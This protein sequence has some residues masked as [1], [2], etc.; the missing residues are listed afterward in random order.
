MS[1]PW[2]QKT[3][4]LRF[5]LMPTILIQANSPNKEGLLDMDFI[6]PL[7]RVIW[8][9]MTDM[10]SFPD[11]NDMFMIELLHLTTVLIHHFP[12][13]IEDVKKDIISCAWHYIT[14]EDAVV[15]QMAYLLAVHFFEAFDTPQKFILQA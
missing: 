15:K 12:E 14:S 2:A 4:S 3:F 11:A 6:T 5:V 13:L 7:H 9:P 10:T 1:Y 8:Q